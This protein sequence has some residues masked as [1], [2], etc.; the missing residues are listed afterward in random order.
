METPIPNLEPGCNSWIVTGTKGR[1]YELYDRADVERL[2]WWGW[3]I[4]T[5]AQYLGRINRSAQ[6]SAS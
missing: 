4:E 6:R 1:V 2:Y 5:A 3:R